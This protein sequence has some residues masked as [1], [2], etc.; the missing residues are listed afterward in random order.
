MNIKT[1]FESIK[2][3][4]YT[5]ETNK[6]KK[7]ISS[8][9][10]AF[11]DAKALGQ[12]KLQERLENRLKNDEKILELI[13][14]GYNR[15]FLKEDI[16][17]L[18]QELRKSEAKKLTLIELS[19]YDR[20]IPKEQQ[21]KIMSAKKYFNDIYILYTDQTKEKDEKLKEKDPIAFGI[22]KNNDVI[23]NRMFYICD[24]VDEYCDLTLDKLLALYQDFDNKEHLH[25]LT[26]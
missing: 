19:R 7:E 4:V 6:I 18:I 5:T 14:N 12:N 15:F 25:R 11:K 23:D 1:L 24:W 13:D 9:N 22:I 21:K 26:D 16:I 3:K 8:C 17:D 2:N 10:K 20:V